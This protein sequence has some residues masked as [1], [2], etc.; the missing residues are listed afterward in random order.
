MPRVSVILAAYYSDAT[1]RDCLSA[2]RRQTFRDFEA[3]VVNSSPEERTAAVASEF[4]EV[5]FLQSPTRLL[6]HAA[7]NLGAQQATGDLLVFS[8]A[9]C[10][11]HPDWLLHLVQAWESGSS[12]VGGAMALANAVWFQQGVHL[13]KF[14]RLLEGQAAGSRWILPT[15]NAAYS[16][17]AWNQAGP[18]VGEVFAGDA[19]LTWRARDAGFEPRF[20]PR[21]VVAHH[22]DGTVGDFVRQRWARGMEFGT[23]RVAYEDWSKTRLFVTLSATPVVVLRV[24][25]QAAADA[26]RCG[27]LRRYLWTFPLQIVGHGGW[28][29]GEARGYWSALTKPPHRAKPSVPVRNLTRARR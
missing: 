21:A 22:H 10:V 17:E 25:F 26:A 9:D 24:L 15:A 2:L 23:V 19:I 12:V 1:F 8:D 5:L 7:R 28:A 4:P 3:I 27:W 29:A 18:F 16:R 13:C 11:A 14:H 20:Q 6:P